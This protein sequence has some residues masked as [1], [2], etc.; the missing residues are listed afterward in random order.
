MMIRSSP[1]D[2]DS[3]SR[4][5]PAREAMA[6]FC[7]CVE[8]AGGEGRG[9]L[10]DAEENVRISMGNFLVRTGTTVVSM[11]CTVPVSSCRVKV[12]HTF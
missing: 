2:L 3:T 11:S 12:V 8:K 4:R 6:R 5:V 7:A 9:Q 10:E 1:M